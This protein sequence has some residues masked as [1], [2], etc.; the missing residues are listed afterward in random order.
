MKIVADQAIPYVKQFFSTLGD[1]TLLD[2]RDISRSSIRGADCLALRSVTRVD[3]ELLDGAG[4]RCIASATSGVDHVNA[5]YLQ[6][7]AIPLFNASGCNALAVA[8]YVLSCLLV[9]SEQDDFDP[10]G[11]TVGIIGCGQV[12]GRLRR[13]LHQLEVTTRVYD[14]FIRDAQGRFSF[15]NLDEVRAA[16]VLSLHVPLTRVTEYPTAGMVD[17][18]FLSG[19]PAD[20]IIINTSRGGVINEQ[21]LI[22]F[23]RRNPASRLALD[24]WDNEPEINAEL[25]GLT[26]LATP[27]IAGYSARAKLNAT[28]RVYEQVC[29]W[30]GQ[31]PAP[32]SVMQLPIAELALN[33]SD[34]AAPVEAARAA[35]LSCYDVRGD[36]IALKEIE[37]V[38]PARRRDFFTSLR[39]DYP[40]RRE[41]A[42]LRL[43]CSGASDSARARFSGL[44]FALAD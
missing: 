26:A 11:K 3:G 5:D 19:L 9:L 14:P 21:D 24:V 2:S 4:V 15:R 22:D 28:R 13:L 6:A 29:A 41:F 34:F 16:D 10:T 17:R 31:P 35:A 30:A 43:I 33:L 40:F 1:V 32:V 38:A 12:G 36:C 42:D 7:R 44:G 23:V 39:T 18:T 25:L 8:Q 37:A 20:V 27:H